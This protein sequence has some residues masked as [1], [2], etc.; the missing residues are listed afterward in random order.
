MA[1][2]QAKLS[3]GDVDEETSLQVSSSVYSQY[4]SQASVEIEFQ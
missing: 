2:K 4:T 1:D 3:V